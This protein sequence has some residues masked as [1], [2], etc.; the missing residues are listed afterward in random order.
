MK[1]G[2]ATLVPCRDHESRT[3][4]QVSR[5][6]GT[7]RFIPLDIAAGLQL[8]SAR[9]TVF[10]ARFKP[11]TDYPLVKMAELYLRYSQEIGATPEALKALGTVV[12]VPEELFKRITTKTVV[13]KPTS[14]GGEATTKTVNRGARGKTGGGSASA[15]FQE[16]IMAGELTDDELFA[17][18]QKA[19][20]L[21]DDKRSYVKWYRNK[22]KKDGK[23]PPEP[24]E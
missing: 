1:P 7:V 19:F 3:C 24:K 21:G 5:S 9:D 23:N 22:L 17:Q 16:L 18:V 13:V 4:L 14:E 15:M 8:A 6:G 10:D 2:A 11:M 20:K 12:S